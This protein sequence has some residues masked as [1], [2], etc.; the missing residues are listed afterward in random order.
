MTRSTL[1]SLLVALAI[2]TIVAAVPP[3]TPILITNEAA[4]RDGVET[5]VLEPVWRL[6]GDDDDDVFFGVIDAVSLDGDGNVLLADVQLMQINVVA[7]DGELTAVLGRQGEGPGEVTRLGGVLPLADG[8][9]GMV[10][11]MPGR[12]VK[13]DPAG[14]PAGDIVPRWL[15][16]G[17]RLMLADIRM[18]DD[19][20]VAAGRRMGGEPP[21]DLTT[22]SSCGSPP[23]AD[24]TYALP[25]T[26]WA[27]GRTGVGM[28]A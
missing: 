10:Q 11:L 24:S 23:I 19:R 6:G 3:I 17:G 27:D 16:E 4:P 15:D 13:V 5:L 8:T 12:V 7:P 2:P 9:V 14:L 18:A 28:R 21:G 26:E 1:L 20:L 25:S 22:R